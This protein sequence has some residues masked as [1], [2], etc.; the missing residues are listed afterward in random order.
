MN[1]RV[2]RTPRATADI[3]SIVAYL[4]EHSDITAMRF[5]DDLRKA[6]ERLAAFPNSGAPGLATGTRRL[7]FDGCVVSYRVRHEVVEIFA[8]RHAKRRDAMP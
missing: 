2:V 6:E 1:L 5:L 4:A 3:L 7:V 8:V